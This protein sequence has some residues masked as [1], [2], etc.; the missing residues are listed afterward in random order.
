MVKKKRIVSKL[1][2]ALVVLT[3]ISCCFLGSTFARYT[4]NSKASASVDVALWDIA[5]DPAGDSTVLFEGQSLTPSK[6]AWT[7]TNKTA[8]SERTHSNGVV[9]AVTI[10]N[11]GEVDAL[12]NVTVGAV[13]VT[14]NESSEYGDVGVATDAPT[15]TE[16]AQLF[17]L[18]VK[19]STNTGASAGDTAVTGGKL[20]E[21]S[22]AAG[23]SVVFFVELVWKSADTL[24][25]ELADKLDSWVGKNAATVGFE[26]SYVAVQGEESPLA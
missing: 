10:T 9:K 24:G 18:D 19:Y 20:E 5:F 1:I 22:L 25:Q 16:V 8:G 21:Y 12:L 3:A 4:S 17:V 7:E 26:I 11:N 23:S 15:E 14:L 13:T 6:D 2:L